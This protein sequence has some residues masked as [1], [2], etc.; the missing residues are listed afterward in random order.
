MGWN[1]NIYIFLEISVQAF[2]KPR[3]FQEVEAPT[4]LHN[5]HMKVIGLSGVR[6]GRIYHP[7]N[8]RGNHFCCGPG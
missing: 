7:E 3:G 4:F 1:W 5:R 2:E 6:T 8:I